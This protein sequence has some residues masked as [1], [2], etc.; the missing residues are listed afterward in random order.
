MF[1]N[2]FT[3][4]LMIHLFYFTF[5]TFSANLSRTG[6]H[7]FWKVSHLFLIA[8]SLSSKFPLSRRRLTMISLIKIFNSYLLFMLEDACSS[9]RSP[10]RNQRILFGNNRFLSKSELKGFLVESKC[11]VENQFLSKGTDFWMKGI[12]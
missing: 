4:I 9:E 10:C 12:S 11:L 8:S 2:N 3:S 6:L 1:Y 5:I 7:S